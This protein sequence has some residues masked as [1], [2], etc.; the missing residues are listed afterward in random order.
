VA[1]REAQDDLAAGRFR[2]FDDA[3]GFIADL[4]SLAADTSQ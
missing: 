1:E 3:E 4:E 2:T